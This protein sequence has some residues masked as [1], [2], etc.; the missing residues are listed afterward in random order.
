MVG[1]SKGVLFVTVGTTRFN[2]L[3]D[4]VTTTQS[5][6]WMEKEGFTHLLIQY[7]TGSQPKFPPHNGSFQIQMECYSFRPSLK[8]DMETADLILSHAGAGT[9]GYKA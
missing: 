9:G 1:S 2:E 3:V 8:Q 7:G 4:A 5:L 6:E